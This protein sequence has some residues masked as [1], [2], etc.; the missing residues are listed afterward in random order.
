LSIVRRSTPPAAVPAKAHHPE[1]IAKGQTFPPGGITA[2]LM[3]I[4][5]SPSLVDRKNATSRTRKD[6]TGGIDCYGVF[7]PSKQ[8]PLSVDRNILSEN[9]FRQ[10]RRYPD[11]LSM[12]RAFNIPRSLFT[13]V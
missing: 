5:L 12:T 6:V 3:S 13:A 2:P 1:S 10:K 7:V 4:Q 8:S 9:K 11:L